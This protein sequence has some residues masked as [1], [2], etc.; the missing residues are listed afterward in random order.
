MRVDDGFDTRE[1]SIEPF[2]RW[3]DPKQEMVF[4]VRVFISQYHEGVVGRKQF[5]RQILLVLWDALPRLPVL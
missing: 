1:R 4:G 2:V 3:M 5:A